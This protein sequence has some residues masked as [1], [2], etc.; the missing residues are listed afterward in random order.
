MPQD[1]GFSDHLCC[2]NFDPGAWRA[3]DYSYFPCQKMGSM[4]CL[5]LASFVMVMFSSY[6][7]A[8]NWLICLYTALRE[9]EE[10]NFVPDLGLGEE[11]FIMW[12]VAHDE[13]VAKWLEMYPAFCLY[14]QP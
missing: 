10:V 9:G 4:W 13:K 3:V 6:L 11:R 1:A 14:F 8:G 12:E 2:Q 7:I 5:Q